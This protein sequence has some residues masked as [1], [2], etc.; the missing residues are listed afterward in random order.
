MSSGDCLILNSD[1]NPLSIIPL[2]V[3]SWQ[4]AIKLLY[5]DKVTAVEF[6]SDWA[7]HSQNL[8]MQ[9][10]AVVMTKK[11][12]ETA[13]RVRFTKQNLLYR[14]N[15]C[16]QYCGK[17]FVSKDLTLDHVTPKCY[18]GKKLW[19]NIVLACGPCNWERGNNARIRPIRM[20]KK[21]TYY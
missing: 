12:H 8:V 14:D 20:P 10:P 18:G 3:I 13:T 4:E 6:Y 1:M 15:S 21:P 16:C 19:T 7:V 11:Y 17:E 5:Q 2:S 9:V